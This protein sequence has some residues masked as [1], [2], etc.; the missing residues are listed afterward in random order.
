MDLAE[1]QVE[2]VHALADGMSYLAPPLKI[3]ELGGTFDDLARQFE[4]LALCR[5]FE[6]AD[7]AAFAESMARSG[8]SRRFFLRRSRQEN[9]LDDRHLAL[10]RTRCFLDALIA[11]SLALAREIASLSE[12]TWNPAWEYEDDHCF[13]L[14]LHAIVKQ[15]APFPTPQIHALLGR[16]DRSLE[17]GQSVHFDVA[18]ALVAR[19]ADAFIEAL[20]SLLAQEAAQIEKE[21]Q[22]AAVRERDIL[23]WPKSRASIEG[24]A[25]LKVG[26]L[27][28]LA[29]EGEFPLCPELARLPWS[30]QVYRDF[31]DEIERMR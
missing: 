22:S 10:S 31:F 21:R 6:T 14:L 30:D 3:A 29:T 18:R 27:L 9:N 2:L 19:D 13:Y 20:R 26:E 17:G 8:Q 4:G 25:L 16:F 28:G 23:F 5:L 11:G 7:Q 24:L 15:P 12:E 1:V